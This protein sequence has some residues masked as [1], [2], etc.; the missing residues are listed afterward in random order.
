VRPRQLPER[1]AGVPV[2]LARFLP[3]T[4][5]TALTGGI[6]F[7]SLW[8]WTRLSVLVGLV[9][10]LAAAGVFWVLEWGESLL[11]ERIE[12]FSDP[13]TG[14]LSNRL[15]SSGTPWQ[16]LLLV[17][18]PALGGLVA[19]LISW[20]F[21]PETMGA[22]VDQV[23]DAYHNHA[24]RIRRRVPIVKLVA[25]LFTLGSGGSSGREGPMAH[26]GA[27][28]GSYLADRLGLSARERRLLLLAG[29]AGGVSALFRAP[30]GAAL[31]SLEVLYRKDFESEGL[32]PCLV[33]SVTAYSV[34]T[35]IY[36]Q[37]SLFHVSVSYHFQPAQL[38]FYGLMAVA[39]APFGVLWIALA[40]A[41]QHRFWEPLRV[42][43][44]LKPA[45]G[46]LALG[47][48]CLF[49]PWVFSTGYAWMQDS[50]RP[51]HD[52]ARQ[53]PG[54]YHGFGVLLGLAVAKMLATTL[55]VCSG[56]SGGKFAPSLFIGGFIGGAFGLLFH[57]LAPTVVT[58][59]TAFVL[60]GMG[61]FYAGIARVPIATIILV[62]ELFGS[63][64]LLVP[65][66]FS[67][68][69]TMLLLG[70]HSLYEKQVEDARHSPA[71]AAEFTIDVLKDLAVADH[72]TR[73]RAAETIP[74]SMNLKDF[75]EHVSATADSFFVVRDARGQL[76]GI[77]SLSNVRAVVSEGDFLSFMLVTDAMWP[78]KSVSPHDDLRA[79]LAIFLD[80]RYDHLPVVD[81]AE[82]DRVL[83]MLTQQQIFA[84]YNAE[85][86]RRRLQREGDSMRMPA[87]DDARRPGAGRP[88][89]HSR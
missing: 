87:I 21:A 25:T 59:P 66:M 4:G 49:V 13:G 7:M 54:G 23:I 19:G 86:L 26:I 89:T 72:Y 78:F 32:F 31:W 14:G 16:W 34:F 29:A 65:L 15:L 47:V 55:T 8:R 17:G 79:A 73:G 36:E 41:T 57:E 62:S 70:R 11:V 28:F 81:P 48:M 24:G 35:T 50:L 44:W 63:Y 40:H 51:L 2:R 10:G 60:V 67:Q 45:L 71:H 75:L 84:A 76:A 85:L 69:I 18:V 61:A 56:G 5:F 20:R 42:P 80:S 46:G 83:G 33:S 74:D 37:G 43:T 22:G 1:L 58:Q 3:R 27:G 52:P 77:V 38:L 64:E 82:P 68:M 6:E 88:G 9:T 12:L 30:L 39:C 53:L